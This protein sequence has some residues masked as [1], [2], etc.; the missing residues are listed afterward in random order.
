MSV[1]LKKRTDGLIGRIEKLDKISAARNGSCLEQLCSGGH[2][3]NPS[4]PGRGGT[5]TIPLPIQEIC[6]NI[7]P[8]NIKYLQDLA[9]IARTFYA[10]NFVHI[11]TTFIVHCR[12]IPLPERLRGKPRRF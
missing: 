9:R 4:F 1:G 8:I 3:P 7:K 2:H 10:D 5:E 6:Q 12:T 11:T